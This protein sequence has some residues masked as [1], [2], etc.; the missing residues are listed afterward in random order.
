MDS[1]RRQLLQAAALVSGAG[2]I[3]PN[4][5]ARSLTKKSNL[6]ELSASELTERMRRGDLS[7]ES[8]AQHVLA[9]CEA[10]KDLNAFINLKPDQVLSDA[11]QADL[12]RREGA[13]LGPLHGLVIPIK[14]SINTRNLPT[15]SGTEALRNFLPRD[16]APLVTAIARQGG[17]L[18]GK[19]NLME[20][21]LGW[22][23]NNK[24][25][26]AV[27][28]PYDRARIPG[29]SSGGSAAAVAAR[30]VPLAVGEDTLGS[31][32][33]PAA[34]CGV[35]GL[36]PSVARYPSD[37]IM[38]ITPRWDAPGPMARN[39]GDLDLFDAAITGR[40]QPLRPMALTGVRIATPPEYFEGLDPE[41]ERV[42]GEALQLLEK[43]GAVLVKAPLPADLE[44]ARKLVSTIQA[45]EII[46]NQRRYLEASGSTM[47]LEDMV[48]AMST[49]V[50]NRYHNDFTPGGANA[51]TE[52]A[53]NEL[54][55]R[56]TAMRR[57]MRAYF[58]EQRVVALASPPTLKAALLIGEDTETEI[59]GK[60]LPLYEALARNVGHG[61]AAGMPC[62][63]LPAGLTRGGLPVG[64]GV[65][66]LPDQDEQLLSLGLA[67][68]KVLGP[69]PP[70]APVAA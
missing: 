20:M 12:R 68:E 40:V 3:D 4:G 18:L 31:I 63:V 54:L 17:V 26:G 5:M 67:L 16:D 45:F 1:T 22:T 29:G 37:G 70:P 24:P 38:P 33:I 41:V 28:N 7:A 60:K 66:M 58:A 23:S 44:G 19:T 15:T 53:R 42:T 8:Y 30:L 64:L 49:P 25:F 6:S 52:Q 48:A 59:R 35:C 21:S 57:A 34:L 32:R 43:A 14:D 69:L 36:R 9:Q 39:V 51:I 55:L 61:S 50:Q 47:R 62:L 27:H 11:R 10:H 2:L 46:A 13:P 65:D 56:L